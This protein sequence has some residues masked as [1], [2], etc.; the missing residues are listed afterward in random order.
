MTLDGENGKFR[1]FDLKQEGLFRIQ[2]DFG[3]DV[4]PSIRVMSEI[5]FT[6]NRQGFILWK[7]MMI[8][9]YFYGPPEWTSVK[10]F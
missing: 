10:Q 1:M 7:K 3:L 2:P 9:E 8:L 6:W 4:G 5:C